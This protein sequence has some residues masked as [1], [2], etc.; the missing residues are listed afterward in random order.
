VRAV[1]VAVAVGCA[2][3]PVMAGA[4]ATP[5]PQTLRSALA[6]APS[7]A[8]VEADSTVK[9]EGSL[10]A[11]AYANILTTDPTKHQQL[12]KGL[13]AHQF[14]AGYGRV[15]VK[16]AAGVALV[17]QILAFADHSNTLSYEGASKLAD[18]TSSEYV[19]SVD[20]SSVP[21]SYGAEELSGGFKSVAIAFVKGNDLLL[22]A[23]VSSSDYMV[24]DT[25]AQA[26]AMYDHAPDFTVDPGSAPA[27]VSTH[28]A[29]YEAGR[30]AGYALVAVIVIGV[31]VAAVGLIMRRRR[32]PT[33]AAL[34]FTLSGDGRFWWDGAAWRDAAT[35][36]PPSAQRSADGAFWWDGRTWRPVPADPGVR[37]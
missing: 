19:G 22:V 11:D 29:A 7:T 34:P 8:F 21:N 28:S 25:Q 26:K 13:Q 3:L 17:E 1:V 16:K 33:V 6:D 31:L 15:W 4:V 10:D 36:A 9:G 32:A 27:A 14:L 2:L 18:T 35:S 12:V 20:S 23:F 30:V 5:D 24:A 37:S